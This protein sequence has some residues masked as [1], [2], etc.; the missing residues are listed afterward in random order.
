ML[1]SVY[2][3]GIKAGSATE[4]STSDLTDTKQAS[5]IRSIVFHSFL[6]ERSNLQDA[7]AGFIANILWTSLRVLYSQITYFHV[8]L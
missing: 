6:L 3:E 7:Q 2:Y 4:L 8:R 5:I 1:Y